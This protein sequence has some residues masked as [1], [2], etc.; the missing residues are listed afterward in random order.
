MFFSLCFGVC[1]F[2]FLVLEVVLGR[3]WLF[4]GFSF[5]WRIL[6]V[7]CGRWGKGEIVSFGYRLDVVL[8]L[9]FV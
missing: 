4:W 8:D 1:S 7:G 5:C 3:C 9:V 2:L 6:I